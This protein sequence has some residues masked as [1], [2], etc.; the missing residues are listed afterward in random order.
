ML[1]R[2]NSALRQTFFIL[3]LA[4]IAA[5]LV[6][7][8]DRSSANINSLPTAVDTPKLQH[9][10]IASL[11]PLKPH[12][13][14][15]ALAQWQ[16]KTNS[17]DYLAE[18]RPTEVGYLVWSQFPIKVYIQKPYPESSNAEILQSWANEVLQAIQEWNT[19]LPL[20]VIEQAEV[21]DIKIMRSSPPLRISPN[22]K[23]PRARSAET[24]Y[25]LYISSNNVLS[26]RC[27]ILLSPNQTGKYLQAAARHEFGHALGI[28]GHS[29]IQSDALYFSQ[30][31]NPPPISSRDVNTLKR[32]Y[33]QPTR[34]GWS[35]RDR[36]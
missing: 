10:A 11:P 31:R 35:L 33:E 3:V 18:I 34:L 14:P 20:Q 25:E 36:G 28:W 16:D 12:S 13:L 29:P 23:F 19:Y 9:T 1:T 32:V 17:G 2:I 4:A 22:E 15:P 24:S 21:A 6:V 26:H 27:S 30:V 5:L 7:M 8:H